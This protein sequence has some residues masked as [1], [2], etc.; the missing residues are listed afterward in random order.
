MHHL[1]NRVCLAAALAIGLLWAADVAHNHPRLQSARAASAPV[2]LLPQRPAP[3]CEV[4]LVDPRPDAMVLIDVD[5]ARPDQPGYQRTLW[6]E[7]S[8]SCLGRRVAIVASLGERREHTV[9]QVGYDSVPDFTMI[10]EPRY[11]A[12]LANRSH[13]GLHLA[14]EYVDGGP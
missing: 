11:Q 10:A 12:A 2:G 7:F 1:T 6:F 8:A 14:V 9:T 4:K 3:G 5:D 13:D